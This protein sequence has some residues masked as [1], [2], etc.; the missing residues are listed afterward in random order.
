MSAEEAAGEDPLGID[1]AAAKLSREERDRRDLEQMRQA[2]EQGLRDLDA[3]ETA[4]EMRPLQAGEKIEPVKWLCRN[5]LTEGGSGLLTGKA[6]QGKSSLVADFALAAAT[7]TGAVRTVGGGWLLDFEGKPVPTYY[8]DT[9]NARSLALRRLSS[10]AREKGLELDPLLRSADLRVNCL[11]AAL[12]PPFLSIE[13]PD[14]QRD[15]EIAAQWA[16]RMGR[17][18]AGYQLLILDV[19]SHCYQEDAQ[20]R[21]ELSQGFISDFFRII[22]CIKKESGACVLLIHHQRKGTGEGQEQASGSSQML[23][24]PETLCSLGPVPKDLNPED[25]RLFCLETVGRQIERGGKV[26]LEGLSSADRNCLVFR[27]IEEPTKEP[28]EPGRKAGDRRAAALETLEAALLKSPET[29]KGG[30]SFNRREWT[31]AAERAGPKKRSP[32]TLE[33][34]LDGE[35][36]KAGKVELISERPAKLYRLRE[37]G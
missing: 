8:L 9:E 35:L 31:E 26:Y 30:R 14:L 37:Q 6:K 24:T 18:G 20:G 36:I 5:F 28:G 27:Q 29:F 11:E 12:R 16:E 17:K 15:L 1:E 21:D 3:L 7:G 13:K 19:M 4:R 22:N 32:D 25:R 34:Y 33:G 23:R 2:R 10:L